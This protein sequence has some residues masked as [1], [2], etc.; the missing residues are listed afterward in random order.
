MVTVSRVA[1]TLTP[2]LGSKLLHEFRNECDEISRLLNLPKERADLPALSKKLAVY[3]Y[4]QVKRKTDGQMVILPDGGYPIR[5]RGDDFDIIA[6]DLLYLI[7]EDFPVDAVHSLLI[8]EFSLHNPSLS[9]LRALYCRF[10]SLQTAEELS[11]IRHTACSCYPAF[12]LRGWLDAI[13]T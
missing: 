10:S 12:R 13:P 11:A 8:R 2:W 4:G 1:N 3:L 9:A 7:F 6:D 5:M